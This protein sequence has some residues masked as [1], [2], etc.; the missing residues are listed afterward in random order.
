MKSYYLFLKK[1]NL[2]SALSIL[3]YHDINKDE[4]LNPDRLDL[5]EEGTRIDLL[6]NKVTPISLW[7]IIWR[8]ANRDPYMFKESSAHLWRELGALVD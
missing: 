3:L 2:K 6:E 1:M 8:Q 7:V 5:I 4:E